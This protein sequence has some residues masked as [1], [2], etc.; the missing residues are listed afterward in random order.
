M[1]LRALDWLACPVCGGDLE[2]KN[3][4]KNGEEIF[5]GALVC[6]KQHAFAIRD[7]VPRL[8]LDQKLDQAPVEAKGDS[9][10]VAASFGAEWSHFDYDQDRTWHQ[11]VEERRQ[12][13]LKEVK[14]SAQEMK[15]K[16]VLDAGAGNGSLSNGISQF[17]CEV[18]AID[19][20]DSVGVAYKQFC[21]RDGTKDTHFVQGDLMNPPFKRDV[22]DVIF[23]S[24]V[25]HH[26]PNTRDALRAIAK[27]L[28]AGGRIYIW[29]YGH[30]PGIVHKGKEVFR[31]TISP[32]PSFV[33]H[34]IV[35][36]WL[37]QAMLRQYLRTAM[38]RN[39]EQD[40]LKWS[41]RFI[42]LLDHYTPR[43]RWEHTPEEVKGWYRELGY[44]R[45]E[46][47]EDRAWGFGVAA[48]RPERVSVSVNPNLT[49]SQVNAPASI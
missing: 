39:T 9:L 49:A 45:I 30:V 34:T 15:G 7:G 14:M 25:L 29:L 20:S 21:G 17:G 27:A 31:R 2:V 48:S 4:Q 22:F 23:S 26:N 16:V 28:K 3:A 12:L 35:A 13:F 42:L 19:V 18:L 10:S 43:Y 41:E 1:K 33:K 11:S 5:A 32:M 38:G 8:R 37:P 46:Q 24:G 44:E 40:R 6:P 47:T 36:A